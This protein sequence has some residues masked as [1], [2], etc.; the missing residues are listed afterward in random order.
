M[1]S[2]DLSGKNVSLCCDQCYGCLAGWPCICD[3]GV[4]K[5]VTSHVGITEF[6]LLITLSVA[7]ATLQGQTLLVTDAIS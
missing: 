1:I 3:V 5:I 7:L 2:F 6:Y 4:V